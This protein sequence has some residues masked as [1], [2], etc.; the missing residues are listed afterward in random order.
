MYYVYV[1]QS[2]DERKDL[3]VGYSSDL[4]RRIQEH[5]SEMNHGYTKNRQWKLVYY[6]A[7][8]SKTDAMQREKALKENGRVKY[9][10]KQ[11]ILS[12]LDDD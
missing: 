10:L 7:Y 9:Q 6:E 2:K 11:R 3:N 1:I 4:K 5:N 8:L 12:S